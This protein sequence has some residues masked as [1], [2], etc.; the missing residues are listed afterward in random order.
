MSVADFRHGE[1]GDTERMT[2]HA[3]KLPL[4]RGADFAEYRL[5]VAA[6]SRY[7]A[8]LRRLLSLRVSV[9]SVVNL[10]SSGW[11]TEGLNQ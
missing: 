4:T 1:H 10:H 7:S 6:D 3:M 9:P 5:S 11:L 8:I 2:L